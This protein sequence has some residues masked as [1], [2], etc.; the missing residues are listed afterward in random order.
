MTAKTVVF[1]G[2]VA[3]MVRLQAEKQGLSPEAYIISFFEKRCNAPVV[4]KVRPLRVFL[5]RKVQCT[6]RLAK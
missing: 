3:E 1:D 2:Y 6:R 5:R 4:G